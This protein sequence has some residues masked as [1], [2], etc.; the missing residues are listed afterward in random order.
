M[1]SHQDNEFSFILNN[2]TDVFKVLKNI[3][4]EFQSDLII[5]SLLSYNGIYM[6]IDN[7]D[8]IEKYNTIDEFLNNITHNRT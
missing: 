8:K 3:V 7:R 2:K 1:L 5:A 6:S 4:P